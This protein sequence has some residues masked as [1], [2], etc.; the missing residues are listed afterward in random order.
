MRQPASP[1]HNLSLRVLRPPS[2]PEGL[3]VLP[4]EI[5]L[6]APPDMEEKGMEGLDMMFLFLV[7]DTYVRCGQSPQGPK[8]C[9]T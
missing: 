9:S 1:S 5:A 3:K 2:T 4:P 7:R 8:F 6:I